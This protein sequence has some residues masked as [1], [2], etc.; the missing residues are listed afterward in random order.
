MSKLGYGEGAAAE[1]LPTRK[2][3]E[4]QGFWG[5]KLVLWGRWLL[6]MENRRANRRALQESDISVVGW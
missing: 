2:E 5:P 4:G 3:R 6:G 1:P